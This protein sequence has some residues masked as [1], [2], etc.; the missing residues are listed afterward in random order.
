MSVFPRLSVISCSLVCALTLVG[1]SQD[2]EMI[3]MVKN[4]KSQ[5]DGLD[6]GAMLENTKV[7]SKPT[8]SYQET[9][10]G[11]HYVLFECTP[12]ADLSVVRKTAERIL[13]ANRNTLLNNIKRDE[14]KVEQYQ[15]RIDA[16]SG[17]LQTLK[18]DYEAFKKSGLTHSMPVFYYTALENGYT[19]VQFQLALFNLSPDQ[20][21]EV[22]DYIKANQY[23]KQKI[24]NYIKK[25][26]ETT[27]I[28]AMSVASS[29]DREEIEAYETLFNLPKDQRFDAWKNNVLPQLGQYRHV[30]PTLNSTYRELAWK[31]QAQLSRYESEIQSP[32]REVQR[33]NQVI[34][35]NRSQINDLENARW[36][37]LKEA[38]MYVR[39]N[40]D[41]EK[42][43]I[44]KS[45]GSR[46]G[47]VL[48]W[49]D[50]T[51]SNQYGYDSRLPFNLESAAEK[52]DVRRLENWVIGL[53]DPSTLEGIYQQAAGAKK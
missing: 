10:R 51:E 1:C 26:S 42:E 47:Y 44:L 43:V 16:V 34:D 13:E 20:W 4:S 39:F 7:C 31:F 50:G 52:D 19:Q 8:W 33:L 30:K 28:Y 17:K 23:D 38:T 5:F 22:F 32:S 37:R 48:K 12:N 14:A 46:S 3:D 21:N 18:T 27:S 15:K 29:W 2:S 40:V 9:K 11:E 36:T 6:V 24:F 45:Y 53:C 35:R 49:E 25:L 41:P